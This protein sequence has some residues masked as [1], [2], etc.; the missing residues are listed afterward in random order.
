MQ[1]GTLGAVRKAWLASTG[2]AP[3]PAAGPLPVSHRV[4]REAVVVLG[5]GRAILLQLAHPLVAAG[6]GAHSGFDAGA[7]A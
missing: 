1:S 3:C 4:N 2:G 7:V 6:V 5:W